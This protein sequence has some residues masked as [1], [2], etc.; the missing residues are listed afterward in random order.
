VTKITYSVI[1]ATMKHILSHIRELLVLSRIQTAGLTSLTAVFGIMSQ[2]MFQRHHWNSILCCFIIGLCAHLHGFITNEI[3]DVGVDR[4]NPALS[5]KPLLTG[6]VSL[7]AAFFLALLPVAVTY[8][9]LSLY[10]L[11]GPMLILFIAGH[12]S[13]LI[14]NG[15]GKRIPALDL[16]LAVWAF[17]FCLFGALAPYRSWEPFDTSGF[18]TMPGHIA[19]LTYVIAALG[20]LQILFNNSVEGGIKDAE[21]DSLAGVPSLATRILGVR[22]HEGRII[23][24][25]KFKLYAIT[26]KGLAILCF[27]SPVL[28]G[29]TF[30]IFEFQG[31][32]YRM[33]SGAIV[34]LIVITMIPFLHSGPLV[35]DRLKRA[36]SIH[37]ILTYIMVPVLLSPRI[38]IGALLFIL[39]F[40]VLWY[41]GFNRILYGSVFNPQV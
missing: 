35:R 30:R 18:M 26:V 23:L 13:A 3:I 9:I 10:F 19:P 38:S 11:N 7:R 4:T 40:P 20:A 41:V 36:F 28:F 1:Y 32:E 5:R 39:L 14:Y 16:F 25:L 22:V 31:F 2:G 8:G 33:M 34:L 21:H 27:L 12:L 6:A 15:A 37:E 29:A 17:S 24:P